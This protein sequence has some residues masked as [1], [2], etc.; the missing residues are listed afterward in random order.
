M[1]S[2]CFDRRY[3][4]CWRREEALRESRHWLLPERRSR[5]GLL[6]SRESIVAGGLRDMELWIEGSGVES[7][8]L[9]PMASSLFF[10][11]AREAR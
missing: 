7:F 6:T 11:T 4:D 5:T 8:E 10:G 2:R 9:S 3:E 1:L